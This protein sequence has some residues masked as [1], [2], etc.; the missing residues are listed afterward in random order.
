MKKLLSVLCL[1]PIFQPLFAGSPTTSVASAALPPKGKVDKKIG[2]QPHPQAHQDTVD[3]TGKHSDRDFL[4]R[5][6]D[7]SLGTSRP[8]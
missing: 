7:G 6:R 1:A 2:F 8:G 5:E 3:A 4:V